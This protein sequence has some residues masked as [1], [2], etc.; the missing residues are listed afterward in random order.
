MTNRV[1]GISTALLII[2]S[3]F[4]VVYTALSDGQIVRADGLAGP[5][6]IWHSWTDERAE[7]LDQAKAKFE[8]SHPGVRVVL[9]AQPQDELYAR[10]ASAAVNGF[11]PDLLIAPGEWLPA[12][13]AGGLVRPVETST[14]AQ[15]ARWLSEDTQRTLRSQNRLYGLPFAL[16]TSALF[17]NK[18]LVERPALT[19]DELL[20]Q[21]GAG[22]GVGIGS[23]FE[24]ALWGLGTAGGQLY[25]DSSEVVVDVPALTSWLTWLR[26]AQNNPAFVM[27]TNQ[28]GL[29]EL[30]VSGD[31]A[32]LVDSSDA[33]RLLASR[34][35]TGTLAV[36][37]LPS[38]PGGLAT[39]LLRA[40]ALFFNPASSPRQQ[41][42]AN[43]LALFL[44]GKEQQTLLMRR[45][46]LIPTHQDVRINIR[47][48]PEISAFAAQAKTAIAWTGDP[49]LAWLLT[50]GDEAYIQALEGVLSPGEAAAELADKL[51]A[52][53]D[54]VVQ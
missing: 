48:N 5:L 41:Q 7:F 52:K 1:F 9:V 38:G 27:S 4:F 46:G 25:N 18:K 17:Y 22:A 53:K 32:Y 39:P 19:L 35:Q 11:G 29:R 23:S 54:E 28:E 42:T 44:V 26:N 16:R 36:R 37:A 10:Y 49:S 47:L 20:A 33:V 12:L 30:F 21:A 40:D 14:A 24:S 51:A 13:L 15:S 8:A 3:L 45:A 34:V 6:L 50:A 31:L 2:L 43:S